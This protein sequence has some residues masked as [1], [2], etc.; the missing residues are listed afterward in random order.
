M[1]FFNGDID[2]VFAT[3]VVLACF[4]FAMWR[5]KKIL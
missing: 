1:T 2:K 4:G 5:A 3:L